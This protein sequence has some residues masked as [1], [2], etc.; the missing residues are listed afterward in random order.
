MK[1]TDRGPA[2]ASL[3]WL[4]QVPVS[5][6]KMCIKSS[7]KCIKTEIRAM[8]KNC[9]ELVEFRGLISPGFQERRIS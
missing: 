9:M 1:K 8:K 5:F 2:I 4:G 3:G 7:C 6:G